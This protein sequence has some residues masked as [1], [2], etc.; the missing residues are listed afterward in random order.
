MLTECLENKEYASAFKSK[1]LRNSPESLFMAVIIQQQKMISELIELKA[2]S[3]NI[4][5]R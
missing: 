1:G 2:E 5:T 4:P 3:S